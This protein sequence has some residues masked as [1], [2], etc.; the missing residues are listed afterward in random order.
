[1]RDI[2]Q[3]RRSW[4]DLL[5]AN[6]ARL[7]ATHPQLYWDQ[8]VLVVEQVAHLMR[9]SL[10]TVRRIP[11]EDLPYSR[12]GKLNLYFR[13]DVLRYIRTRRIERSP[14]SVNVD[15]LLAEIEGASNVTK[16][17]TRKSMKRKGEPK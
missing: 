10:D 9:C 8:D 3:A 5:A 17:P 4:A 6:D 16:L 7:R 2:N 1:M 12:P 13:E 15:A 14:I 11:R